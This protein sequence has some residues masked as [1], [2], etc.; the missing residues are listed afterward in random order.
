MISS[1]SSGFSGVYSQMGYNAP[2]GEKEATASDIKQDAISKE[3]NSLTM[4]MSA[5]GNANATKDAQ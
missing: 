3:S 2:Q 4:D 5:S 1:V